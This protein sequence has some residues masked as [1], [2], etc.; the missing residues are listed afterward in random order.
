MKHILIVDDSSSIRQTVEFVL[1]TN[2]YTVTSAVDGLDALS[3]L[4]GNKFNMVIS[5]VNMP[6]MDGLTMVKE[7]KSKPEYQYLPILMLT[8]ESSQ[9]LK[10]K[11]KEAGAK[12][13]LVKPFQPDKLLG[14]VKKL[15]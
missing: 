13:W 9:E 2:G 11:G 3:K 6:N 15:A 8:T 7:I 5:D 14:A 12:A 10:M 1:K 4:D